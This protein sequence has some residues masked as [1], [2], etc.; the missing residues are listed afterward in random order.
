[1][2]IS[3]LT[4]YTPTHE[5]VRGPSALPYYLLKYRG[6]GIAV[7]V[8]S[9]NLN[10]VK[11]EQISWIERQLDLKITILKIPRWYCWIEKWKLTKIRVFLKY[12]LYC[13]IK[14]TKKHLKEL[15]A[16]QPD[17][18]WRYPDFFIHVSEQLPQ[19]KHIV[20]GPDCPAVVYFR[21]LNDSTGYKNLLFWMGLSK[22]AYGA[23]LQTKADRGKNVAYHVVGLNDWRTL[24]RICPEKEV[25]FLLHPHYELKKNPTIDFSGKRLKLLIAGKL[26][27]YMQS[28]VNEL[29]PV[30][31]TM[32]SSVKEQYEMTLLGKGWEK[33]CA[34]L[35]AAGILCKHISWVDDYVESISQY[36]IQLSPIT[37]GGGMKGKVLDALAN[38]L[39]VIG[40]EVALENIA[41]R[42]MESCVLYKN[43]IQLPAILESVLCNRKKY[44]S[45]ARKGMEQART[46]HSPERISKRFFELVKKFI[47]HS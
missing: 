10:K 24:K 16:N 47:E 43:A 2:K 6:S 20:T 21:Q 15:T 23:I 32:K 18:I 11:D 42:N 17:L 46:Y 9:F 19:Y 40:T 8:Y 36:D 1:M 14:P 28:G 4:L 31:R 39:L 26:D 37:V 30:L 45:I 22:V 12:P 5:N 41:V 35:N 44:E 25:F 3:L 38:G 29:L 13:Y 7:E 33:V 27:F 34:Q